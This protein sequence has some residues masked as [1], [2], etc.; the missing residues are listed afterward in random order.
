[1][2]TKLYNYFGFIF[3]MIFGFLGI[4]HGSYQGEYAQGC[5]CFLLLLI[6]AKGME[7]NKSGD[8]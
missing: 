3:M 4:Y 8:K 6:V 1:M 5:Y 7:W 2:K